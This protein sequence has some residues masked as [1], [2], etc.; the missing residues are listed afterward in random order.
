MT[1]GFA[2]SGQRKVTRQTTNKVLTPA[3]RMT[4]ELS[5]NLIQIKEW[6]SA[7]KCVDCCPKIENHQ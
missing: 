2:N 5:S 1:L 3:L 7:S 6:L 4:S